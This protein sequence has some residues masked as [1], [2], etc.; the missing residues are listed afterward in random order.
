MKHFYIIISLALLGLAPLSFAQ[1]TSF[2]AGEAAQ[3][4]EAAIHL[5]PNLENGARVFRLCVV[6]HRPEGWGSIDGTYPQIAGQLSSVTIKQLADIRARNRDNPTMRPFASPQIMGGAQEIADVAA[7]IAKLPM[8]P[9]NGVG[10]GSDLAY[11]EKLF[12]ENC[13]DCHGDMGEGDDAEHVPA[14]YGQHYNYLVRQFEWIRNGLRRN[15]DKKMV[16]QIRSFTAR[17]EAAVLDYA[18][19]LKPPAERLAE[20]IEWKN[21]DFTQFAR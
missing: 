12:K 13:T 20:S 6:C 7:Y 4:V 19:R 3:E 10:M 14:I 11:G 15:A 5:E 18:S 2:R 1:S 21:P 8:A 16:K 17:D 9:V